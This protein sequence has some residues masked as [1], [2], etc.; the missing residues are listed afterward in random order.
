[1]LLANARRGFS[2]FLL[3]TYR[4]NMDIIILDCRV[5][6]F[7]A[8]SRWGFG[9]FS[10]ITCWFNLETIIMDCRVALKCSSQMQSG[11]FRG[12]SLRTYRFNMDIIILDC[13]VTS[14]LASSRW[15]FCTFSLRMCHKNRHRNTDSKLRENRQIF[16]AIQILI[17]LFLLWIAASH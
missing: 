4:F 15:G 14:F 3:I 1:M 9:T 2:A 12:F 11:V 8:S 17:L 16:V 5:T 10:L 13:R 7:L 6:S